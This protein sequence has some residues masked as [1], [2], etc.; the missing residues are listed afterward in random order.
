MRRRWKNI[1]AQVKTQDDSEFWN[2]SRKP[3]HGPSR[4]DGQDGSSKGVRHADDCVLLEG[5][6]GLFEYDEGWRRVMANKGRQGHA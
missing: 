6:R 2:G 3:I 5:A 4:R 1:V